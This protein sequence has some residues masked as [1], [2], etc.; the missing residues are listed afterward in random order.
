MARSSQAGILSNGGLSG[1]GYVKNKNSIDVDLQYEAYLKGRPFPNFK[2]YKSQIG[3]Q[4]IFFSVLDKASPFSKRTN[5]LLFKALTSFLF[6]LVL[7]LFVRWVFLEIGILASALLFVS[8][9]LSPWL[10]YF[11]HHLWHQVWSAFL[12]FLVLIYLLRKESITSVKQAD[13]RIIGLASLAV[14]TGL[15]FRGYEHVTSFLFMGL[16]PLFYYWYKDRW[17]FKRLL[18]R[19]GGISAGSFLALLFTL[20][21]LS[22]QISAVQ[23]SF[24]EG[25]DHIIYSFL[26]R[27]YGGHADIPERIIQQVSSSYKEVFSIYLNGIALLIPF[28]VLFYQLLILFF[29]AT[30]TGLAIVSFFDSSPYEANR[31]KALLI[32][33]WMAILGPVSWFIVFK[34]HAYSHGHMDHLVWYM[35]FYFFGIIL[36]GHIIEVGYKL[37]KRNFEKRTASS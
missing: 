37:F 19:I 34:G 35:P 18:L 31:L 16:V 23:G 1:F 29:F 25:I 33:T 11:G 22:L 17:P 21:I 10:V 32:T 3:F 9:I 13:A 30:L 5:L 8:I 28:K 2:T 12:P 14:L 6:A 15:L 27:S 36:T 7:S 4:A 26:K 20:L 24:S